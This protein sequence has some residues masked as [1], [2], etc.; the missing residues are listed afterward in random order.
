MRSSWF[1]ALAAGAVL[2]G[3]CKD[4]PAVIRTP[5]TPRAVV[6]FINAVPDTLGTDW[7]FIDRLTGSPV[8]LALGFRSVGPYQ[9]A[10]PGA[11]PLRVFPAT[12]DLSTQNFFIDQAVT[13]E[14][15]KRYSLVHV[16][17]SRTGQTPADQLLVVE[18]VQPTVSANKIAIRAWHLGTGIGNVDIYVSKAGGTTAL[19]A[20]PLWS[21]VAYLARTPYVEVDP[22][23]KTNVTAISAMVGGYTRETGSFAT[24][25]F[26]V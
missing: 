26:T 16:G 5:E 21:N 10:A 6:R 17:M 1:T 20:T 25:G 14:A 24:D 3:G 4:D 11:R 7:R 13:L 2:V 9:A 8:E 12:T 15:D 22:G 18:D 23:P 19:P